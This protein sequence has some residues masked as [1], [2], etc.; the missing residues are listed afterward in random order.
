MN[1]LCV[2]DIL[3]FLFW[4]EGSRFATAFGCADVATAVAHESSNSKKLCILA[5][6]KY[7]RTHTNSLSIIGIEELV[8]VSRV[9]CDLNS[10]ITNRHDV[11]CLAYDRAMSANPAQTP[12][13]HR[14]FHRLPWST[15]T[16][17][18]LYAALT[19]PQR[20]RFVVF[21][22]NKLAAGQS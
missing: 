11:D 19:K 6:L 17:L 7:V 3:E 15:K 9:L 22:V 2:E 16:P 1:A 20:I 14:I 4:T 10:A 12:P 5:A 18:R 13:F 21:I 8:A